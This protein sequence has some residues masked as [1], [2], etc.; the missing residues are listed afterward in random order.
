MSEWLAF[1]R[2]TALGASVQLVN[3]GDSI[4]HLSNR[5]P[6]IAAAKAWFDTL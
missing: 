2:M 6:G 5:D 4:D 3:L 1:D